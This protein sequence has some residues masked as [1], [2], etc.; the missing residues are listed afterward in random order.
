MSELC[1]QAFARDS[2]GQGRPESSL[3]MMWIDWIV[4]EEPGEAKDTTAGLKHALVSYRRH[5]GAEQG[6]YAG[7]VVGRIAARMLCDHRMQLEMRTAEEAVAVWLQRM[8]RGRNWDRIPYLLF[9]T[10]LAQYPIRH[11]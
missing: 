6:F 10:Y 3:Q 1:W 9:V 2:L 4:N 5:E 7:S 11:Q 8:A